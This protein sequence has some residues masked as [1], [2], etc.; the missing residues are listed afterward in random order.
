M[1]LN[2]YAITDCVYQI[3][4]LFIEYA[5]IVKGKP[6]KFNQ[7]K[8]NGEFQKYLK[9]GNHLIDDKYDTDAKVIPQSQFS[10][11]VLYK[12]GNFIKVEHD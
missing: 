3:G 10:F 12:S 1:K 8:T 11:V 9:S 4:K 2:D 7:M 6:I 5:P